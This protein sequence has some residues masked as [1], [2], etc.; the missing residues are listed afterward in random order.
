MN[1]ATLSALSESNRFH[2]VEL[3]QKGACPVAEISSRLNLNQPQTSKHLRVLADAG[4]VEI[5]PRAQQRYYALRPQAFKEISAWIEKY[6]KLWEHRFD[7]LE[8][9]LIEEKGSHRKD[10]KR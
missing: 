1:P 6:R 2:I 5:M 7:R 8:A 9:L 3:L 4:L 10:Y